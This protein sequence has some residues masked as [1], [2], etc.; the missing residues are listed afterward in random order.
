MMH[1]TSSSPSGLIAWM[2]GNHVAAN[3]LMFLLVIGG[4]IAANRITKEVF[5]SYDLDIVNIS[6]SYPGAS[7]EEVEQGI[8][9]AMEEEIRSLEN[10][11]RVTSTANEGSASVRVELLSGVNPD[12]SLQEIKNGIDR[13]T[14]F[15]DD[16]ERPMVSLVSRRREV[17][18]LALYG[19]LDEYSLFGLAETVREDLIRLPQINQVELGGTRAPE[20]AI[21]VPQHVLRAHNL[22]LEEVADTVRKAAVDIPAGGIKTQG[23]EILLRTSERRETALE[24]SNL[25][26]ISQQDGT[27]LSLSSIA[28]IREALPKLIARPGITVSGPL[29]SPS[30]AP[31]IRRPSRSPRLCMPTW[32][33]W[34]RLCLLGSSSPPLGTDLRCTRIGWIFF[35]AT[36]LSAC[37]L[38]S[39][40]W[41]FSWNPGWLSGCLWGFPSLLSAPSLSSILSAAVSI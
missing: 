37:S 20:L 38:S 36:V 26:V 24:F 23:G 6:M 16:V 11:E 32:M 13:I 34:L 9:L 28:T 35:Y 7:P 8:I 30:I 27:E 31:A 40:P 15:P 5:P 25:K 17:L 29:R 18:R 2:A 12:K 39:S 14:S 33:N 10:I 21:E 19:D 41:G 4:L 1:T 22:T 3:L